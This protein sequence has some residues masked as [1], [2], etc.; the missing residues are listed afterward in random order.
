MKLIECVP[1]FSEGRDRTVIGEITD[2]VGRVE[3]VRLL[4]VDPGAA[5]NRTVVTF[6]G[7]PEAVERAA[8]SAIKRASELIDM[9][10][11][12]GEHPRMGATDVCPF[13]PLEGASM[14]DCIEIARRL[15]ERVGRE[16][17]IPVFLYEHAAPEG[18]RSL[19]DVRRGEY[20]GLQHRAQTPDFGPTYNAS[21]GATAIGARQFLIAYNV[22][23]NTKDRR[24]AH[25]I[26][27]A[28]RELGTPQ[29]NEDGTVQKDANGQTVFEPGRFKEVK[30][31]GWYIDEYRRAQVSLNLT[32]FSESPLH[33][34]FDA[35]R[36]EAAKLGLRVTGSE[37]IGLVPR[38]ALLAAG[39]HYLTAQGATTGAPEAERIQTAVLSLGLNELAPFDPNTKI[40]EYAFADR[41]GGLAGLPVA[42][43]VDELSTATPAPG[44]GSAAA[45][46]G[47]LGAALS[48]MVASL[49]YAKQGMESERPEMQDLGIT[50]QD[51]KDWFVS[52]I[53]RDTDAFNAVLSARRLPRSTP[54]ETEYRLAAIAAADLGATLVPL[55]VLERSV[56]AL[57][58]ILTAARRGNPTSVTDAGVGGWCG[59]A[60][61]EGASM[62]VRVNLNGLG[63]EHAGLLQRH[64]TALR[65]A[66]ELAAEITRSVEERL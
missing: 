1:N 15:G 26:A 9:R 52:A 66:R 14:G 53:D 13:V 22:N 36:E 37:L 45:L 30:G 11:H 42:S 63:G 16:L 57:E 51:L 4:D 31:V 35:C 60:A 29:R 17:A 33:L 20:E 43:F 2:A 3:G 41:P 18:R 19:A 23:L 65:K 46:A 39:D 56:D 55:E 6:V 38:R 58:L 44:G 49:T 54:A 8:F 48:A 25:R 34:V 12:H 62:N 40:I 59:L 61:A 5:T 10:T 50:A 27:Q 64:D 32:D 21:A 24:L 28:V 47:A 7:P